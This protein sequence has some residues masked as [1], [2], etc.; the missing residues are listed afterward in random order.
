M[1]L[2][3]KNDHT[4]SLQNNELTDRESKEFKFN[5]CHSP[6]DFII[7]CFEAVIT[8]DLRLFLKRF[9]VEMN[10]TDSKDDSE[11]SE[12][13]NDAKLKFYLYPDGEIGSCSYSKRLFNFL[14]SN[15][16]DVP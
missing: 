11:D 16:I 10:D 12:Y 15:I 13:A 9:C 14:W 7:F 3:L 5:P 6:D 1:Y 2:K 4:A 8:D